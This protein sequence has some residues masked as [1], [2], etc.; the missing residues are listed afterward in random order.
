MR[1]IMSLTAIA[2]LAS[3]LAQP[4]TAGESPFGWIYTTDTHPKGKK[5]FEQWIETQRGQ[6]QGDYT[7]TLLRSEF[8]YGVSDNYQIALYYNQRYVNAY[9]NG[10][11]GTT[12]GPDVD[13][14]SGFDPM[15]RYSKFRFES[16]SMENLYRLS[17]P[18]TDPIGMAI[19]FEPSIGP[20]GWELESKF[21]LQKNFLDDRLI[22]AT[23]LNVSVERTKS[24][25]GEV[26]RATPVDVLTGLSYRFRN[27]WSAGM[28]ARN[29]RE[30][31]GYGFGQPDHSAW[32]IGPNV[33]YATKAWWVTG[34]W[35]SQLKQA[36]GFT[37]EQRAVIQ[38]GRIYGGEHARNEFMVKVGVPF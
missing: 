17:N 10:I 18:Y 21:I 32:F 20:R 6:S 1:I 16:V 9:R 11:D 31:T 27:N 35:R 5:E 13:A 19:Y 3:V 23:N 22:W 26:E 24:A 2:A 29:H 37:D 7:N 38:N 8:E 34:A 28:E 25:T 30:F 36:S 33:H 15:S 4:A 14:P 12:G